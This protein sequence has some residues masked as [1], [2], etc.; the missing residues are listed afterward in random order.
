MKGLLVNRGE[1]AEDF[2]SRSDM[3]NARFLQSQ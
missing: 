3:G 1:R 2:L